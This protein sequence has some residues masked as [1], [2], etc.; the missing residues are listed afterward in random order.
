[1][2][3]Y[4]INLLKPRPVI[5]IHEEDLV[6]SVLEG[7]YCSQRTQY[8]I[9]TD[10]DGNVQ[11][12]LRATQDPCGRVLDLGAFT[13]YLYRGA[14]PH[15]SDYDFAGYARAITLAVKRRPPRITLLTPNSHTK[16]SHFDVRIV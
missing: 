4:L 1:M 15:Q 14:F 11:A 12:C 10:R 5:S 7:L 13:P 16:V 2:W 3:Q 9:Y 6:R 8:G